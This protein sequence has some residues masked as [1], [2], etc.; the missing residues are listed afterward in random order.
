MIRLLGGLTILVAV[1][2]GGAGPAAADAAGPTDYRTEVVAVDPP[3]STIAVA[4]LGGDSFVELTVEPGVEVAVPG[5]QAEPYLRFDADGTV[6]RNAVA[7]TTFENDDRFGAP[8]EPPDGVSADAEPVWEVVGSGGRYAWHDHRAHWMGERPP[9]GAGPGDIVAGGTIPLVVDGADVDLVVESVWQPSASPVPA[10]IGAG[11]AAV[12]VLAVLAVRAGFLPLLAAVVA[13]LG[14]FVVVSEWG[15]LPS[16]ARLSLL[17]VAFPFLAAVG[18]AVAARLGPTATGWA[19]G[20]LGAVWLGYWA[21]GRRAA[22]D[23]A[24]LPTDGSWSLDRA[25]TAASL[26]TAAAMAGWAVHHL[27]RGTPVGLAA[28]GS[29]G[30]SDGASTSPA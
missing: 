30:G 12:A 4:V 16:E 29:V 13:L 7:P 8:T 5:Y 1:L 18:F 17:V 15:S 9:P 21:F 27:L 22:L 10:A 11:V 2:A 19:G 6:R 25:V 3:T 23:A 14:G 24:V 20:L 28:P 26:V